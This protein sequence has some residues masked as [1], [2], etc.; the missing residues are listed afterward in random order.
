MSPQETPGIKSH[1]E[2]VREVDELAQ[3]AKANH[4]VAESYIIQSN[5]KV[6][7]SNARSEKAI[8]DLTSRITEFNKK[9]GQ[10]TQTLIRLTWAIAVLTVLMLAGLVIQIVKA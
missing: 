10:Q 7:M 2:L 1:D 8:N 3:S 5:A 6:I 4:R 9:A